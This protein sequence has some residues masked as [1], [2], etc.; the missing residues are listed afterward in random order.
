MKN[1]ILLNL[2][3][4]WHEERKKPLLKYYGNLIKNS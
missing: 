3:K 2:I 1:S 4:F